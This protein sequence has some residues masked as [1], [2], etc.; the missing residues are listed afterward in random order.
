MLV[1]G[2]M[3][4]VVV[5]AVAVVVAIVVE[6]LVVVE[7]MVVMELFV[8]V[9]MAVVVREIDLWNAQQSKKKDKGTKESTVA[10]H[11]QRTSSAN[12]SNEAKKTPTLTWPLFNGMIFLDREFL[13]NTL[14]GNSFNNFE[15]NITID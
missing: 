11:T 5:A 2:V 6:S 4:A 10:I 14:S 12:K 8:V 9:L 1:A 7:L 13:L 15:L 3:V